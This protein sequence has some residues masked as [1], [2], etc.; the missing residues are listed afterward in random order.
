MS[1]P[2]RAEVWLVDLGYLGKVRPCLVVASPETDDERA[3]V[4]FLPLTTRLRGSVH[5]ISVPTKFLAAGAFDAQQIATTARVK[6]L[7]RLG[8]LTSPEMVRVEDAL[9]AWLQL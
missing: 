8:I 1:R 9:R 6:F 4:S 7:R 5:E 3:L 2:Q